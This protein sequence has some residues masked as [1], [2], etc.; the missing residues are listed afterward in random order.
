MSTGREGLGEREAVGRLELLLTVSRALA[1][2]VDTYQGAVEALVEACVPDFCDLCAVEVLTDGGASHTVASRVAPGALELAPARWVPVGHRLPPSA[3]PLLGWGDEEGDAREAAALR[4]RLGAG[5]VI[6]AP[7]VAGGSTA[8]WLIFATGPRR[9]AFRPSGLRVAAELGA[10]VGTTMQRVQLHRAAVEAADSQARTARLL[11]RLAAASANLAGADSR[12]DVLRT[13][14]VEACVVLDADAAA[15]RW[16]DADGTEVAAEAGPIDAGGRAAL[17]DALGGRPAERD[18]WRAEPLPR[19]DRVGG[20]ALAVRGDLG[21]EATAVLASLAAL[22]PV[23]YERATTTDAAAHQERR[24]QAVLDASPVALV[25]AAADGEVI[26]AN[27]AAAELFGWRD[28]RPARFPTSIAPAMLA[29]VRD[30]AAGDPV[31]GWPVTD[32]ELDLAVSAGPLPPGSPEAVILAAAD[33]REA[34]AAQRALLQAQ[35][36]EAMGQ[37]AGGITHDFNNLLTVVLGFTAMLRSEVP[38]PSGQDMLARIDRAANQAAQL[39]QRLLGLTRR[40]VG[41]SDVVD[42]AATTRDLGEVLRRVLGAG[43]ELHLE[44]PPEP[45]P[46]PGEPTELEQVVLNLAINAGDAMAGSGRIDVAVGVTDVGP[47]ATPG[48]L[49]GPGRYASLVVRD[50]GPGMSEEVRARCVEPFFTTKERGRGTG[51]GLATVNATAAERG[52]QLRID[53]APGR[54][55]TVEVLLPLAAQ[56]A[57]AAAP[58][59]ARPGPV[60]P[61]GLRVLLVEDDPDLL[62]MARAALSGAGAEVVAAGSAEAAFEAVPDRLDVLVTDVVLPGA[63][64][65]DV[66]DRLRTRHPGL[67]VLFVT[68]YAARDVDRLAATTRSAL[69]RKPYRPDE[70]VERLARLLGRPRARQGRTA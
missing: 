63:S 13:A 3:T 35:R 39:T 6:L 18:G 14:C 20:A 7:A 31:D 65:A 58:A 23:A 37:V 5:S 41:S 48:R 49:L 9:R 12:E 59:G 60:L 8:G 16:L 45:V 25:T 67:P 10:R 1:G 22:V 28:E 4:D 50:D 56:A 19:S 47:D 70:L 44:V 15:A 21:D 54:G 53:T 55:T 52:G 33:M 27:P 51:L 11:R 68:G 32:G 24:L 26:A 43:V 62:D 46:V 30:A 38:S 17:A 36:L 40:P 57:P 66:A 61:A 42:L 34:R 64:G 29:A 2:A 69:L